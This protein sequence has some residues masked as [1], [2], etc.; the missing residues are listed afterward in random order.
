MFE[1]LKKIDRTFSNFDFFLL[2]GKK[3]QFNSSRFSSFDVSSSSKKTF[4]ID[5]GVAEIV[6][7]PGFSVHFIRT[8]CV[9]VDVDGSKKVSVGEF[10][11][12]SVIDNVEEGTCSASV[13]PV[14][15]NFIGDFRFSK[16]FF[17]GSNEFS[18]SLCSSA[19]GIA[20]RLAELAIAEDV[21]KEKDV[22]VVL[23]GCLSSK[24]LLCSDAIKNLKEVSKSFG[25]FVVG[26]SKSSQ[27]LVPSGMSLS[28]AFFNLCSFNRWFY[29]VYSAFYSV[30]FVKFNEFSD[31]SFRVDCFDFVSFKDIVSCLSF[32][33]KDLSCPGYPEG[34]VF[35]DS[36]SRVS[37]DEKDLLSFR[38]GN[39]GS[40][41]GL[42]FHSVLDSM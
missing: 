17:F 21:C 12:E 5:G 34:L 29:S 30:F 13:I 40:E 31:R 35:A 2:D 19:G 16:N 25:S 41:K 1:A 36:I 32:C 14:V 7:A 23:D 38:Y 22:V 18:S 10:F 28:E 42:N 24:D 37:N 4:F 6:S 15:G 9:C 26:V 20:L 11:V 39:F 33:C 27:A 3:F 8:C